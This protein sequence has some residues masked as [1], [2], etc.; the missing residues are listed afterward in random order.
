MRALSAML[1]VAGFLAVAPAFAADS[2]SKPAADATVKSNAAPQKAGRAIDDS[3]TQSGRPTYDPTAGGRSPFLEKDGNKTKPAAQRPGR[4]V[5]DATIKAAG[6]ADQAGRT[7]EDSKTTP[8]DSKKKPGKK[9][10]PAP[11]TN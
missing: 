4:S 6:A 3:S 5:D 10:A 1:A 2:S 9:P 8:A 7:V 11:A